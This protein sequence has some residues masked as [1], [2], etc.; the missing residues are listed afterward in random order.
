MEDRTL[1]ILSLIMAAIGAV[2][3]SVVSLQNTYTEVAIYEISERMIGKNIVIN[4]TVVSASTS[5]GNTF[6]TAEDA[7]RIKVVLFN[8]ELP[9]KRGD[10]IS[11][12]GKV[13]VYKN[14]LEI[15]AEKIVVR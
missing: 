1:R 3:L 7:G 2:G 14:E 5:D 8:T 15:V 13:N 6:I 11:A 10:R 12:Y 4:G 9:V